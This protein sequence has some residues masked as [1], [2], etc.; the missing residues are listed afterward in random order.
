[1]NIVN[2]ILVGGS[3]KR[4]WPLSTKS[5]PKQFVDFFGKG[6]FLKLTVNRLKKEYS[7]NSLFIITNKKYSK[8]IKKCVPEILESNIIYEPSPKDTAPAIALACQKI[9][10][11]YPKCN[12]I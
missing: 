2:I 9:Y 10:K 7:I 1:M 12:T 4:F 6:S 8:L 11:I 3:G 5:N